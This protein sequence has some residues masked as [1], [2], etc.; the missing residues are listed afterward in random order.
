[1]KKFL[2]NRVLPFVCAF[3]I[4]VSVCVIPAAAEWDVD[5][6]DRDDES[7]EQLEEKY[8]IET[9]KKGVLIDMAKQKIA[10][11]CEIEYTAPGSVI[12]PDAEHDP[13]HEGEN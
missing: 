11:Y 10:D 9:I 13:D 7:V 2:K 5:F 12:V 3:S 6:D 4:L 8:D 1:M